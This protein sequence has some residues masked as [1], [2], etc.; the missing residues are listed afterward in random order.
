MIRF[1]VLFVV[2]TL[3][4]CADAPTSPRPNH[5]KPSAFG[6]FALDYP[7]SALGRTGLELAF[8]QLERE[9]PG[10]AGFYRENGSLV[11]LTTQDPNEAIADALGSKLENARRSGLVEAASFSSRETVLRTERVQFRY[12]DLAKW[13]LRIRDGVMN[14]AGVTSLDLNEGTNRITVVE[15]SADR[16]KLREF[17]ASKE[18]PETAVEILV[19]PESRP[20]QSLDSRIRPLTAGTR[21]GRYNQYFGPPDW[22]PRW[23][24]TN[25]CTMGTPAIYQ[26]VQALLIVSHCTNREG[27]HEH[28]ALNGVTY[29]IGQDW[30][31]AINGQAGWNPPAPQGYNPF[32]Y[33][34]FD[35]SGSNCGPFWDSRPCRHA[36]VAVWNTGG[37][38]VIPPEVPFTLGRI[39]RP[40]FSVPGTNPAGFTRTINP[41]QPYFTI[42]AEVVNPVQG[43]IVQKVGLTTGWTYGTVYQTCVDINYQTPGNSKRRVW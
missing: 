37:I 43:D 23:T 24:A 10:F 14:L 1:I 41:S 16:L 11:V 38:E 34:Q 21:F 29:F 30:Y 39:A 27:I 17:L 7:D 9:V 25:W 4:A 3:S 19:D 22:N 15:P 33:E 35:R 40:L 31:P 26:G 36:E 6:A 2:W 20:A 28:P 13:R 32:G 5:A 18:V 8:L 12:R 42:G